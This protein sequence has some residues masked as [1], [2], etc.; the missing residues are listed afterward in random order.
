MVLCI[1]SNVSSSIEFA[2]FSM[3][4]ANCLGSD[5]TCSDSG[6]SFVPF[7]AFATMVPV[8]SVLFSLEDSLVERCWLVLALVFVA[9]LELSIPAAEQLVR[10]EAVLLDEFKER[11]LFVGMVCSLLIDF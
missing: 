10:P 1:I 8:W 6:S 5:S 3:T 7:M 2:C 11:G 9:V 4:I